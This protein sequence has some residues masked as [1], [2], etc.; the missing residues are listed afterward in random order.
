AEFHAPR[1]FLGQPAACGPGGGSAHTCRFQGA[2][3]GHLATFRKTQGTGVGR[4]GG[5]GRPQGQGQAHRR[6]FL[7]PHVAIGQG[8]RRISGSPRD[9]WYRRTYRNPSALIDGDWPVNSDRPV[10]MLVQARDVT[11]HRNTADYLNDVAI[12]RIQS[13]RRAVVWSREFGVENGLTGRIKHFVAQVDFHRRVVVE[14]AYPPLETFGK[15]LK[16]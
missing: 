16:V 11:K 9:V 4:R 13:D 5:L 10:V 2:L 3:H 15:A 8:P 1:D 6:A 12:S 7:I 14:P